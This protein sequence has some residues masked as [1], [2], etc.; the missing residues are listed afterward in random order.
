MIKT[1]LVVA[2]AMAVMVMGLAGTPRGPIAI[3]SDDEF[4]EG[5]GVVAGSGTAEDPYRISGW[6]IEVPDGEEYGIHV[7]GTTRHFVVDGCVVSGAY[8][9][10]GA[11][12]Y[13]QD[14]QGGALEDSIVQHSRNGFRIAISQDITMHNNYAFVTGL[15]LQVVG[16]TA[17]DF[18]HHI[19]PSNSVNGQGVYYYYGLQGEVLE[20]VEAGHVTIAGSR[21][22]TIRGA[23]VQGGDGITVAFSQA[24][25]VEKADLFQNQGP[26]VL[27]VSSP[28]TVVQDCE[29][30]ANNAEAGVML[31]LSDRSVV[32]RV[33]LYGNSVG[34]HINAS[35]RVVARNNIYAGNQVGVWVEG[36]SREVDITGGL[37]FGGKYGVEVE[38]SR[39]PRVEGLA[40][41]E[42]EIAISIGD[43]VSDA[44]VRDCTM[45]DVGYGLYLSGSYG[46]VERN[47]IAKADIAI[48]FPETYGRVSPTGNA[49]R[50]NVLYRSWEGLYLGSESRDNRVYENLFW[51]CSLDA[52]DVGSNSWGPQGRGNWYSSYE[53]NEVE[54]TGIGD[55]P[56][57]LGGGLQDEA[58]LVSFGF[59]PGP[60][61]LLTTL[62]RETVVLEDDEGRREEIRVLVADSA[63]ARFIRLQGVP[64]QLAEDL[65][66]LSRWD[67]DMLR[68]RTENVLFPMDVLLFASDGS[69]VARESVQPGA[70]SP[71]EVPVPFR[72]ALEMPAGLL[73]ELE[74]VEPVSLVQ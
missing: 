23:S 38:S 43:L 64:E 71:Y 10:E 32:Q 1:L 42:S 72:L 55:V 44:V 29:R 56:M 70:E 30:V 34:L 33:G 39:G 24:V 27:A 26:G 40:V 20:G 19:D 11:A 58:P 6:Q 45:V 66:V 13:L 61:G 28:D 37:I 41:S 12:V 8:H 59:L 16:A 67:A 60:P 57:D 17:E 21:D 35:D 69:F 31:W 68:L 9:P 50:H 46:V 3:L 74:L 53:G 51:D 65:A 18:R 25:T 54:D 5:N 36:G 52:R 62:D 48:L 14:V 22:V 15:G 63:H 2:A 73:D 4:T 49:L 47:L 7:E